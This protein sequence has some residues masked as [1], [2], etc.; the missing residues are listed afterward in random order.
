MILG[1]FFRSYKC[2]KNAQFIPFAKNNLENLNVFIGNNGV[3][4]SS[5][6]EALDTFFNNSEWTIHYDSNKKDA[7]VAPLFIYENDEAKEM[8]GNNYETIKMI[9]DVVWSISITSNSNYK[10]SYEKFFELRDKLIHLKE[11]HIIFSFAKYFENSGQSLAPFDGSIRSILNDDDKILIDDTLIKKIKDEFLAKISFIYIPVE[12]SISDFLKLEAKSMQDLMKLDIKEDITKSLNQKRISRKNNGREKKLSLLDII[13]ENLEKFISNIEETIQTLD[14][15]Y[16][17]SK[18]HKQKLNLTANHITNVIIEAYF[19]K[20]RLKKGKKPI[21]TLSSGER[22][23]A[24]IDITYAFLK[25]SSDLGIEVILAIDE[26]ESSLHIS[27]HY[28]QFNKLNILCEDFKIQTFITTHWYGSLPIFKD[29]I[30]HHILN[31]NETPKISQFNLLNYFEERGSHPDDIH[32]KSFYDLSSSILSSLRLHNTNWLLVEGNEDRKYLDYY[33]SL[34][35]CKILPLGGSTIVKK[36]YEYL[37]LPL[38]QKSE[39]K[40]I[41]GKVFCLIDTDNQGIK[42]NTSNENLDNSLMIRRLQFD[43]IEQKIKLK[44]TIDEFKSET[45]IEECLEPKLFYN[46]LKNVTNATN[47][48]ILKETLNAFEFDKKVKT[49]FIKGDYSILN[50]LGNGRNARED[51]ELIINFINRNKSLIADDYVKQKS[52]ETPEWVN[53]INNF[54]EN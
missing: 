33:L 17:F 18:E 2:Y 13:N 28:E 43:N 31:E 7:F 47:D 52:I 36:I 9:S 38:S 27:Q 12:T 54:F 46:A 45:E 11:T 22:K 3:G 19:S 37:Y 41:S 39:S 30:L 35:N 20:R 25:Q 40:N 21:T 1:L 50:H 24:L 32:L 51:K 29:G 49:S 23:R 8:F 44:R 26:P 34:K 16:N 53:E 5:I 48:N 6:L 10:K 15:D 42:L 14:N 4:K